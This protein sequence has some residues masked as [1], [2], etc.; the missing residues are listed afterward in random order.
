ME[1]TMNCPHCKTEISEKDLV[2]PNC[3]KVLKLQCPV[4]GAI[5]KNT[6]CEKCGS[7]ILNK[8]YKC[9]KLNS[10]AL[11]KCPKC[12]LD[13]N[14]SIGLRE[15]IIE[16][17]AV[18]TIEISNF[19]DIQNVFKSE[20]IVEKFKKNLYSLI[21][22][23]AA[24]KKLRVQFIDNTFIIR[25]CKDYSFDDSC[26]SAVDFSIF[27]AQS[28][29]E[30]NQKLFEAKGITLKTQMAIQKRDIYS[31]QSA[32]KSGININVVYSSSGKSQIY[33]DVEVIADSYVYQS[34][35][36]KYPYQSLS[37]VYIKNQM[38]MFLNLY[39]TKLLNWKKKRK[40][41]KT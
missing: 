30:I 22:K 14:A 9:G 39:C 12:G 31:A 28:V 38:I 7:V 11:N 20:K 25:F 36:L 5:S 3:K 35:K 17:F 26:V 37:A 18:L 23:T 32:Y 1:K 15:S 13:I 41:S 27:V 34:T 24:Q 19:D 29:T 2:C 6:I 21:K 33:N 10:T 40:T 4:C 8:C 16:E